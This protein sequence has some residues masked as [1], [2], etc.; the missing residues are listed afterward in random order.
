MT[1]STDLAL[2]WPTLA[3]IALAAIGCASHDPFADYS[4][5]AWTRHARQ[6]VDQARPNADPDAQPARADDDTLPESAGATWFVERAMSA[7]PDIRAA[8]QRVERL[9]ARVPQATAPPDPTASVT[10]GELAQTAAG[11]VAYIVAVQQSLPWP[12]TLDAR[13]EVAR[14]QTVEAVHELAAT[15][16]RVKADTRRAYWSY[17]DAVRQ[18]E[19]LEQSR[20]LLTQIESSVQSQL[21][22]GRAGQ[23]DLLR[24][25][26]Q[27]ASLENRLDALRQRQRT[28]EAMLGRLMGRRGRPL[29]PEPVESDWTAGTRDRDRL[30][31][32]ATQRNPQVM[33]AQAQV[34]SYR[35]RL[36]LARQDRLP[37]LMF[38]AQYAAVDDD[39]LSRVANGDD[40]VAGT[41]GVSLPVW[42]SKHDAAEAEALRGVGEAAARVRAAQDRAAYEVDAA[43]ARIDAKEQTLQRLRE[44]IMPDAQQA[45]EVGLAAY[46]TGDADFLHVLDDWQSLLDDQLAEARLI[47]ELHQTQA[48]L[49]QALGSPTPTTPDTPAELQP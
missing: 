36:E 31:A 26:R 1:I 12:G 10:F 23:A 3:A 43:L 44:R 49:D 33:A 15:L 14:Q 30:I 40:R 17:D 16:D 24:V 13:G 45:I 20:A 5:A 47:A 46:R 48:D 4:E 38:G 34:E 6:L 41:V 39:G 7:N 32:L 21:R 19:V 27:V 37:R 8:V 22:V 9:R 42:A 18:A 28:A 11:E 35:R 2:R 25:S 29:L